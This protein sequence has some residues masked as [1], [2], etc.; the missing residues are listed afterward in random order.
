MTIDI[1]E[2]DIF[3]I[4]PLVVLIKFAGFKCCK[5]TPALVKFASN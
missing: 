4:N 3:C 1:P 5:Q 2:N